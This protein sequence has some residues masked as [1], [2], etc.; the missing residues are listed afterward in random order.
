[1]NINKQIDMLLLIESNQ[2]NVDCIS[3]NEFQKYEK[4]RRSKSYCLIF[5]YKRK[6]NNKITY[7]FP[8]KIKLLEWLMIDYES[9][10][11]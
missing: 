3:L 10:K 5:N 4:G 6:I 7:W 1:M 8:N 11:K 2:K 9:K